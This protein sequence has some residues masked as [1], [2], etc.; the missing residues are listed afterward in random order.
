MDYFNLEDGYEKSCKTVDDIAEAKGK[1]GN[2]DGAAT[3]KYDIIAT[4][5]LN[6]DELDNQMSKTVFEDTE[7]EGQERKDNE[8][9]VTEK[10]ENTHT[11]KEQES[12]EGPSTTNL[13]NAVEPSEQND[14]TETTVVPKEVVVE[15]KAED[16]NNSVKE[17]QEYHEVD[18]TLMNNNDSDNN[19]SQNGNDSNI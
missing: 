9:E 11:E 2:V 15:N 4:S 18:H 7:N 12:Q 10:E 16:Q 19:S 5:C 3:K 14:I 8:C 6:D 1:K 13:S 17:E